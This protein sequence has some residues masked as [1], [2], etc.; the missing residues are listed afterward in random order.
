MIAIQKKPRP[1]NRTDKRRQRT[2]EQILSA[3]ETLVL[4]EGYEDTSAEAIAE[5]ADLGRSTFYNHF[6]NKK[7]A[8]LATVTMHY[9]K[10]GEEAYVPLEQVSDRRVSIATSAANLF[11]SMAKDPLTRQLVDR[12]SLLVQAIVDSQWDLMV[13]DLTEGLGQGHFKFTSSLESLVTLL[14]W[15]FTGLLIQAIQR[16]SIDLTCWEWCR[17]LLLNLGVDAADIQEIL[18][19]ITTQ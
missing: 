11:K 5:L 6:D 19:R 1:P 10:Y 15:G 16:D 9:A 13:N 12:P 14:T 18:D 3:V 17:L 7:D 8:V 2:R 4:K